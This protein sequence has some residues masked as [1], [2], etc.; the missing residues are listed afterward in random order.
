MGVGEMR[1]ITPAS[2]ASA[3]TAVP[4]RLTGER[5]PARAAA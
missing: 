4:A 2:P 3:A 1:N 5:R